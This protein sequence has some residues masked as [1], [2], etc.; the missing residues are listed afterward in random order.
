MSERRKK[1]R[2]YEQEEQVKKE[3][4]DIRKMLKYT[5]KKV[6]WLVNYSLSFSRKD[7]SKEILI[8]LFGSVVL[9]QS[10]SL[11]MSFSLNA[12]RLF[13]TNAFSAV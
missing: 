5:A 13:S 10:L 6:L 2:E 12:V 4:P 8:K 11:I 1:R 3:K 7:T 9:L